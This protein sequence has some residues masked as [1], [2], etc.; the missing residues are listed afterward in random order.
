MKRRFGLL[1]VCAAIVPLAVA[2]VAWACA[3]LA[4]VKLSQSVVAPGSAVAVTGKGY[5]GHGSTSNVGDTD[6][7]LTLAGRKGTRLGT[8]AV[9]AGGRISETILIPND[10]SPGWYTV[11]ATQFTADGTPKPGMPGRARLRIQGSSAAVAAPI[12]SS[13]PAAPAGFSLAPAAQDGGG[14]SSQTL[15]LVG[16]SLT[17]LAAG[18]VLLAGRRNRVPGRQTLSV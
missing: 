6:V 8:A 16:L 17:L 2:S 3:N 7:T 12:G 14:L 18:W 11:T 15:L 13:T 9:D 10:V 4:L 5:S 1:L